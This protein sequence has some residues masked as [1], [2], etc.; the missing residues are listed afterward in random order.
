MPAILL[1]TGALY[2]LADRDD[3]WHQ[4]VTSL[5]EDHSAPLLLPVTVLPEACYLLNTH[6]GQEAERALLAACASGRF[7][8]VVITTED[9]VRS[10]ELLDLYSDSNLGFV[11]ASVVAI[12]ERLDVRRIVTTDRRDFSL[13]RPRHCSAFELLP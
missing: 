4:R 6:L 8:V 2:A 9:I 12:A 11:D 5:V 1:D 3:A 10:I 13:V 7:A